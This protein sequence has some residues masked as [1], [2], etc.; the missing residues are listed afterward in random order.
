MNRRTDIYADFVDH[1]RYGRCPRFTGLQPVARIFRGVY[2]GWHS[3]ADER[4]SETAI[5][6]NTNRQ[7]NATVPV[8][9][10]FDLK[11]TCRDCSRNFIFFA[12]EQRYWY[13]TLQFYLGADCVRCIDCRLEQRINAKLRE[14]YETLLGRDD[15][16]DTESLELADVAM[17]L[18]HRGV[19]GNRCIE[20]VRSFLNSIHG[21]SSVR[22]HA[23]FR[24]VD[25]WSAARI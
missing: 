7:P 23:S 6:A 19:F 20:R 3:R 9:H 15:R 8:T 13:E 25:D 12:E 4:I 14:Q 18:I 22:Q 21:D 24:V 2:L 16:S 10:Y 17:L 11:R 5:V 1:P